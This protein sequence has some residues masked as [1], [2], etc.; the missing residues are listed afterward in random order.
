MPKKILVVDNNPFFLEV[1]KRY[2]EPEG[3]LV[4]TYTDPMEALELV[5]K[6]TFDYIF[7]DHIMPK[8]DGTRLCG[9]LK[10]LPK[11]QQAPVIIL[12]GVAIEASSKVKEINADAY[13]AKSP[14]PNFI[15]DLLYVLKQYD[16]GNDTKE[17]KEKVIGVDKIYPRE[18]TK[19]FIEIENHLSKIL[20]SMAEGVIECDHEYKIFFANQ[21]AITFLNKNENEIIGENLFKV[22][23]LKNKDTE[24][25]ALFPSTEFI[26]END[27]FSSQ[28]CL[29]L[30][31]NFYSIH[32]NALKTSAIEHGVLIVLEDVTE[33][34]KKI[35]DLSVVNN[36]ARILSAELELEDVI[37]KMLTG[38]NEFINSDTAMVLLFKENEP[39]NLM[40]KEIIGINKKLTPGTLYSSN[41][42]S[43][44]CS[45][46]ATLPLIL[47]SPSEIEKNL[48]FIVDGVGYKPSQVIV[49]TVKFQNSC[50]GSIIFLKMQNSFKGF[51]HELFQSLVSFCSVA[52]ENAIR[53]RKLKE[54]NIWRQNYMANI[55]HELRTP[56]TIVKGFNEILCEDMI[57][58]E[59]SRKSILKNMLSEVNKLARLIDNLLTISKFENLPTMFKIKRSR[60]DL[61][62]IIKECLNDISQEA[63]AKSIYFIT[64]FSES[65]IYVEGDKELIT[66]SIYHLLSNSVKYSHAEGRVEVSTILSGSLVYIIIRD[67]GT[68][69]PEKL[70]N[71]IYEKFYMI[72]PGPD[73]ATRGAGIGL[74]LVREII[75]LHY[76]NIQV[77]STKG[78][79]TRFTIKLPIL[80]TGMGQG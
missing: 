8:I 44:L 33:L 37:K 12:T 41:F 64:N 66:Q 23:D 18:M 69:I 22:L 56:L 24:V 75:N 67:Y 60:L 21:S 28:F 47:N 5:K 46:E 36:F 3:Y 62:A 76:G 4:F 26:K 74:Y 25:M 51:S 50:L 70:L 34:S 61:H 10:N 29:S 38:L 1:I 80:F 77:D 6:E 7:V 30:G 73:K 43:C 72:D 53:Y 63:Q 19:E 11:S 79:G 54:L 65:S 78:K 20:S 31:N 16:E 68:G 9:Y 48:G 15:S 49:H 13:V 14:V 27:Q 52:L 71:Q 59:K 45:I 17:F 55:S 57:Q 35:S 39:N 32:I 40:L 42:L 58:D 2:L